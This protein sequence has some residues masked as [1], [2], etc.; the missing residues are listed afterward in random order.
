MGVRRIAIL[1][2]VAAC[3][4]GCASK[5]AQPAAPTVP[6]ASA[7]PEVPA[8]DPPSQAPPPG[9]FLADEWTAVGHGNGSVA[10]RVTVRFPQPTVCSS[11]FAAQ[12]HPDSHSEDIF[13]EIEVNGTY[14]H[15]Y[16][17]FQRGIVGARAST[18]GIDVDTEP[19]FLSLYGTASGPLGYPDPFTSWVGWSDIAYPAGEVNLTVHSPGAIDNGTGETFGGSLR[20]SL[21]CDHAM[22][23]VRVGQDGNAL[24]LT[25]PEMDGTNVVLN[26][27]LVEVH[28]GS[29]VHEARGDQAL[30][31]I[32]HTGPVERGAVDIEG[33]LSK[34][35]AWKGAGPDG[36]NITSA[37]VLGPPGEYTLTW[38]TTAVWGAQ[39]FRIFSFR[40]LPLAGLLPKARL[41]F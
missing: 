28:Q 22:E 24:W 32:R 33:P 25:G 15:G 35:I 26:P 18:A 38:E 5:P 4:G 40:D 1:L 29:L 36:L 19:V 12:H 27:F 17:S 39:E 16:G 37:K 23:V 20:I 31:D 11:A 3:I 6:P 41:P 9:P 7:A 2:V 30:I 34:R 8:I 21:L 13:A 14:D 10:L